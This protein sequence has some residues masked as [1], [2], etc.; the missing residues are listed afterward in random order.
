VIAGDGDLMEGVSGEAASYAGT[1][2]LGKLVVLYDDNDI[3]IEGSTDVTFRED[4]AARFRAYGWHVSGPVDGNDV[5]AIAAAITEARASDLPSLIICTTTIGYG[6][7]NKAG[8]HEV[9]GSPLG[10]EEVRLTRQNLG[11]P[12][13]PE[14]Y[15]PDEALAHFRR[16][17]DEGAR[18]EAEWNDRLASYRAANPARADE[19][20]RMMAG[21][22]PPGWDA[23]M[24]VFTPADG[25]I[26]TRAAGGKALNG[27]FENLP[28]LAGGSA[29]LEPST[30]TWLKKSGRFG[31]EP[32]GR[33]LQF[34][35]REHAMGAIALGMAH[36]GGAIP[37]TATFLVF[38]DYM[39][40]PIRL[41]ALAGQRVIFIF[42]HDSIG[43][44]ED[45]PTHQPVE[46]LAVLR[47]IPNVWVMRPADAVETAEAWRV[48]VQ[49][50]NGPTV[51]ALSR[52]K[53]PIF[54]HTAPGAEPGVGRGAYVLRDAEGRPDVIL[55]GTGSEVA[56]AMDAARALS[57]QGI[58]ARVV[59]MP[60]QEL[61]DAQPREYQAAVLPA[62]VPRVAIEAGVTMGWH[63]YVGPD[64]AIIGL[65]RFG[66]SAPGE[67]VMDRLGFNV[68][69][70]VMQAKA[71]IA[72]SR[73]GQ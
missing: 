38:A 10:A 67:V 69:N 73:G 70:V 7:P 29:D 63:R 46:Q 23:G 12:Q 41:A 55:I 14:F 52:Q 42:T 18:R 61:F 21:D 30:N 44:G 2:R 1:Q 15:I 33:N 25:A 6:S 40:P 35:V 28:D 24:P 49:R 31:W 71:V 4:V 27:L 34:G 20:A 11:W 72:A 48:A 47:A 43:V 56:L 50:R 3:S 54:G 37:Y 62:G 68:G 51:L 39:R 13:E 65:D 22:L 19:F 36:H 26:A 57:E 45:G 53:L 9:H 16:A 64:G 17:V 58:H 66:A 60:C 59:S 5:E 32:G 8:S